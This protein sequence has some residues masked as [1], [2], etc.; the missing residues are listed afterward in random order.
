MLPV[1]LIDASPVPRTSKLMPLLPRP[2]L[3]SLKV[4]PEM[5]SSVSSVP[6]PLS[7]ST[8]FSVE[9]LTWVLVIA[10]VPSRLTNLSPDSLVSSGTDARASY[11]LVGG[12]AREK[13]LSSSAPAAAWTTLS[14]LPPC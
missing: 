6:V 2:V 10:E 1:T 3:L 7:I 5:V 8:S 9:P 14:P 11:Q 12:P 4:L 13:P